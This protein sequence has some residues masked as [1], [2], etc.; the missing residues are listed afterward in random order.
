MRSEYLLTNEGPSV[1]HVRARL[2]IAGQAKP[3]SRI[4]TNDDDCQHLK[5]FR[6]PKIP[7]RP[8][9]SAFL[10]LNQ[11]QLSCMHLYKWRCG[12]FKSGSHRFYS[13]AVSPSIS[14]RTRLSAITW[15]RGRQNCLTCSR[16]Y[17]V[18]LLVALT[19]LSSFSIKLYHARMLFVRMPKQDV[20]VHVQSNLSSHLASCSLWNLSTTFS[21]GTCF[22]SR[23]CLTN[24]QEAPPLQLL[25]C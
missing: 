1:V 5:S 3:L 13:Q 12:L 4:W 20:E 10:L 9:P 11:R 25:F 24:C 17:V 6:F 16:F 23:L 7:S 2:P 15:E 22:I 14:S 21:L 18:T 8:E 19:L